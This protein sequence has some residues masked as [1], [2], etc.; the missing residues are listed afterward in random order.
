M[1]NSVTNYLSNVMKSVKF[2]AI[3]VIEEQMPITSNFITQNKE[4]V[5]QIFRDVLSARQTLLKTTG[6]QEISIFKHVNNA[7][8]NI[9]TDLKS[10]VFYHDD[11]GDPMA[12]MSAL[13]SIMEGMGGEGMGD[14]MSEL[15][16]ILSGEGDDD[17]EY[18]GDEEQPTYEQHPEMLMTRGD[19]L[20]AS[21]IFK[22]QS[23]ASN[24]IG[25]VIARVHEHDVMDRHSIYHMQFQQS[26]KAMMV[27]KTGWTTMVDGF[28]KIIEFNNEVM[29]THATNSQKFYEEMLRLTQDNNSIL[30]QLQDIQQKVN[31]FTLEAE[32]SDNDD[33]DKENI[34]YESL[35][36][37]GLNFA[38]YKDIV[39][40]RIAKTPLAQLSVIV[41]TIPLALMNFAEK[42]LH[43]FAKQVVKGVIG[44]QLMY[45][46]K[47]F[48]Q[49]VETSIMTGLAKLADYGK[50]AGTGI[51]GEIAK[52]LGIKLEQKSLS[53][54]DTSKFHK[55]SLSWNGIAQKALVEI[56]PGH[57]SR[58]E[59]SLTG[60]GER[61]Y[62]YDKGKWLSME[63]LKLRLEQIDENI[64]NIA[65]S[66]VD[67]KIN[68]VYYMLE[69]QQKKGTLSP[70]QKQEYEGL[71][72]KAIQGIVKHG[73]VD[74]S[75][76]QED[77]MFYGA[78]SREDP[79]SGFLYAFIN[80]FND[81]D[82]KRLT[83]SIYEANVTK[84]RQLE[85]AGSRFGD[86]IG[87]LA[88]NS[89]NNM[90]TARP[91][92]KAFDITTPYTDLTQLRDEKGKSLYDY[93]DLILMELYKIRNLGG[94][95]GG[96]GSG[97]GSGNGG[98]SSDPEAL[99]EIERKIEE[100][101]RAGIG[102]KKEV[103]KEDTNDDFAIGI[104]AEKKREQERIEENRARAKEKRLRAYGSGVDEEFE[105]T[106][107]TNEDIEITDKDESGNDRKR[108]LSAGTPEWALYHFGRYFQEINQR[109]QQKAIRH[110]ESTFFSWLNPD[111]WN[112][113]KKGKENYHELPDGVDPDMPFLDQLLKAG[114]IGQKFDVIRHNIDAFRDAPTTM[115][116]SVLGKAEEAIDYVLFS[117]ESGIDPKTGKPIH[118]VFDKLVAKL[119]EHSEKAN[120]FLDSLVE[121]VK[122]LFKEDGLLGFVG[123][124]IKDQSGVDIKNLGSAASG[125]F[126]KF[127]NKALQGPK[128]LG[129]ETYQ[130]FMRVL[131]DFV[132]KDTGRLKFGSK[133][134][135][136]ND[137][138]LV[139]DA[140]KLIDAGKYLEITE[141]QLNAIGRT[142]DS[143][144]K[145]DDVKLKLKKKK[146]RGRERLKL[147]EKLCF[148]MKNR[149]Q[150]INSKNHLK[151]RLMD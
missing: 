47:R 127:V 106:L 25:N 15:N 100:Q 22:S 88:D 20:V 50:R 101:Y 8:K 151:E 12:A 114:T 97:G 104:L 36:Q 136:A 28:N 75:H 38:A 73:Y 105:N 141:D 92:T 80:Q 43:E 72:K 81:F 144:I 34:N 31:K 68:Q 55:D 142:P 64:A 59:A 96:G 58:I 17:E 10:G 79:N 35:F 2:A 21:A 126:S 76:F 120:G 146:L 53:S 16:A 135:I 119:E 69:Q 56:I 87:R 61:Y 6:I 90:V 118:G 132:D 112:W 94:M 18:Y 4:V 48:D 89:L 85:Y 41:K 129:I 26:E 139:D 93:Q 140:K 102:S 86:P 130:G 1:S 134:N 149:Q 133:R 91:G 143:G 145:V 115:L 99:K 121:G 109:S 39:A 128:S 46:M 110:E 57:L 5:K 131:G 27:Q 13:G 62:D 54:V 67:D 108:K 60:N 44:G 49:V 7:L 23:R 78:K 45:A 122:D 19:A 123:N 71:L 3:E 30:K 84:N 98:P 63:D 51:K 32:K 113:M 74:P 138:K 40:K 66:P 14:M 117:K 65:M 103:K 147:L 42:P 107:F 33:P 116:A 82:K 37:N 52:I 9:K 125:E 83:K 24:C 11:R 95:N 77:P 124:W 70:E 29:R 137:K 148:M 111:T 150:L